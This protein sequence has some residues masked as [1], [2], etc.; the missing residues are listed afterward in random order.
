MTEPEARD[1][2]RRWLGDGLEAWMADQ[3]WQAA[4]GGWTLVGEM[5]FWRFTVDTIPGG[6]LLSAWEPGAAP[7]VWTVTTR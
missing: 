3:P 5:E 1:L 2:L 7:A 6:L 4:P